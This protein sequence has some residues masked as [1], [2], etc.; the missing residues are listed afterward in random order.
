MC[1]YADVLVQ[2]MFMSPADLL[3]QMYHQI[4]TQQIHKTIMV[5]LLFFLDSTASRDYVMSISQSVT[6]IL[7]ISMV[8]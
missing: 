8:V 6:L 2:T 3:L 1:K 5:R 7:D 4:T